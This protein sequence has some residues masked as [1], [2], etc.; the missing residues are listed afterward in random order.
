MTE[1][2][3]P[4]V[5]SE[6]RWMEYRSI[7]DLPPAPRNPKTHQSHRELGRSFRRFGYM[8]PVIVDER[9]GRIVAGHGRVDE[10][11][12]A[13]RRAP[14]NPPEGI[15]VLEDGTWAVPIVRGWASKDDDEAEAALLVQ[16]I[17]ENEWDGDLL[18]EILGTVLE[19]SVEGLEGTGFNEDYLAELLGEQN[20]VTGLDDDEE[21][22][23]PRLRAMMY[24]VV[25]IVDGEAA[26]RELLERM[27]AEG[28]DARA[29]LT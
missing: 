11:R 12:A 20:P 10:L 13:R 22:S 15:R 29:V 14:H 16:H 6:A 21:D 8:E 24:R 17:G 25:V 23:E 26:Q 5:A 9:T 28:Y 7:D 2:D 27:L 19:T 1:T 4:T 18:S 3:A